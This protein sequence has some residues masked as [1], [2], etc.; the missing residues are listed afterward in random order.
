M[1]SDTH[2]TAEKEDKMEYYKCDY[3]RRTCQNYF[4]VIH[5]SPNIV[6]RTLVKLDYVKGCIT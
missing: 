6:G 2:Q 4:V 5:A 3:A 1:T